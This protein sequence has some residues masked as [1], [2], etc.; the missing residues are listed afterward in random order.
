MITMHPGEYIREC[1]DSS[2]ELGNQS[3][4]AEAMGMSQTSLSL[5]LNGKRS[6]TAK[7]ALKLERATGRSA[8]SWMAMQI[9]YERKTMELQL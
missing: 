5:I 7:T 6:I 9:D 1:I 3:R 2:E 8:E 4:L